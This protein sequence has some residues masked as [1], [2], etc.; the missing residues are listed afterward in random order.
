MLEAFQYLAS[1]GADLQ[2]EAFAGKSPAMLRRHI[3]DTLRR[4]LPAAAVTPELVE[5]CLWAV[6]PLPTDTDP[7]H[8]GAIYDYAGQYL[9]ADH[10]AED[11]LLQALHRSAKRLLP[12]SSPARRDDMRLVTLDALY[13]P[14]MLP[15]G[16]ARSYLRFRLGRNGPRLSCEEIACRMH[17]PLVFIHEMEAALLNTLTQRHFGGPY[18]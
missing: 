12:Q 1:H 14:G 4:A 11:A 16:M 3:E 8:T 15:D 2:R 9:L 17:K 6:R 7:L 13:H 18:A 5:G 10:P